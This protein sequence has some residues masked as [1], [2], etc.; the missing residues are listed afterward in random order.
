[1][2]GRRR[3]AEEPGGVVPE[4]PNA[5]L[6]PATP[7]PPAPP[8]VEAEAEAEAEAEEKAGFEI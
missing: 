8:E 4:D 7:P 1:M 2:R 5:A 3:Q 6:K